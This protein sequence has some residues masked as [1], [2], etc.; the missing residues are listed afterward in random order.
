MI[1]ELRVY[2]GALSQSEIE[3]LYNQVQ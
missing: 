3:E 1:D 2:D